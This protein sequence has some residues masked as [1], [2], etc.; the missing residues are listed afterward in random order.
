MNSEQWAFWIAL[1]ALIAGAGRFLDDY[2]IKAETKSKMREALINWFIWLEERKI[3]DLGGV[4]F[5][6]LRKLIS[7]RK[8]VL[9]VSILLFSYWATITSIYMGRAMFGPANDR[10]YIDYI[11]NWIPIDSTAPYWLGFLASIIVPA[12]LGTVT[13]AHFFHRASTTNYELRRFFFL[14]SGLVLGVALALSGAGLAYILFQGGGYFLGIIIMAGLASVTLPAFLAV[15]TL[16]LIVI[17][18]LIIGIRLLLLSVFDVAS[19]PNVSPF[20]YA[21][22]LLGVL[23][24]L[25]KVAQVSLA[26]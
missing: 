7:L 10:S 21:S 12:I 13:M 1:A 5:S 23:I 15:S 4:V 25:G 19:G 2:H 26:K 22:A 9:I 14:V 8:I 3:P 24:L 18:F 6:L 16:I 20:T 17:R 11:M